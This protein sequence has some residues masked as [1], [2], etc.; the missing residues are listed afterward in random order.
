MGS[1]V[2]PAASTASSAIKTIQRGQAVSS[3]NI[4]ITAVDMSKSF[5]RSYSEGSAGTVATNSTVASYNSSLPAFSGTVA[6]HN[7]TFPSTSISVPVA[8]IAANNN[9]TAGAVAPAP[10]GNANGNPLGRIAAHTSTLAA[11]TISNGSA[12]LSTSGGTITGASA[13]IS[14]GSTSLTSAEYGVYLSNSTTLVASGAC[15]WEVV[16]FN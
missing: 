8:D 4:T 16:E 12:S 10:A 14:G 2:F 11:A 15:R 5:V 1:T 3:G 7:S 13:A 6:A 9:N